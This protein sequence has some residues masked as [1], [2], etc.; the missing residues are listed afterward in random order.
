MALPKADHY[1]GHQ[2]H[3]RDRG[4]AVRRI[5]CLLL[6]PEKTVK[7]LLLVG[8]GSLV[9]AL[10]IVLASGVGGCGSPDSGGSVG[11]GGHSAGSGGSGSGD[12]GAGGTVT[13]SG[14][15]GA[16]SGSGGA[17][18]GVGGNGS[19]GTAATGAGGAAGAMTT[20]E[21]GSGG[22]ISAAGGGAGGGGGSGGAGGT[23]NGV[24]GTTGA[25]GGASGASGTIVSLFNGTTLS[26]W[27]PSTGTGIGNRPDLWNVQDISL[28][29]TG[30][31]RGTLVSPK[32]Y[33]SFR[34]IFWVRQL[35]FDDGDNHYASFLI[36]GTRP[37][38]N[39]ALGALQFGVPNGYYWDYRVGHNDSGAKY[40]VSTAGG[41]SRTEWAQCEILANMTTGVAKMACCNPGTA[42]SCKAKQV[43]V[44]TDPTAGKKG[45]IAMQNH[46]PGGHDEYKNITIEE[47]PMVDALI[48]TQ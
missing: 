10:A 35:P 2:H 41:F 22:A 46:S 4:E 47:N 32:D 24:G 33:G 37:P 27:L 36:W 8:N 3:E 20:G 17:M 44:F 13:G 43:L 9:G 14:G 7:V 39:D 40:F 45:P 18:T 5:F 25:T 34:L 30:T 21:A 15:A 26:G 16:S 48:T 38:P 42:T 31:V 11:T 29:C 19:G 1:C 12:S 28:H 23:A 6:H